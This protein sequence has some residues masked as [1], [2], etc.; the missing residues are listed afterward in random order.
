M[1]D[2]EDEEAP[3]EMGDG[4]EDRRDPSIERRRLIDLTRRDKG[5]PER[6]ALGTD[7]RDPA[8]GAEDGGERPGAGG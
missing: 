1:A 7:R 2:R 4:A 5:L 8:E 3:V 6:R